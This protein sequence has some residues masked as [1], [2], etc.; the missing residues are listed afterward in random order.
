MHDENGYDA[1][2]DIPNMTFPFA[3][4]DVNAENK[5]AELSRILK[6]LEW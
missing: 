2:L 4:C 3:K 6:N 5:D 1:H